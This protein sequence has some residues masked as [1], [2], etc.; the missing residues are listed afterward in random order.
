MNR[1]MWNAGRVFVVAIG[2]AAL[3]G[4][5]TPTAVNSQGIGA[6]AKPVQPDAV[7]EVNRL[8][9]Q[10]LALEKRVAELEKEELEKFK[11]EDVADDAREKKLEQRLAS[12]EKAQAATKPDTKAGNKPG[13]ADDDQPMTVRAPF[14]VVDAANR[15]IFSVVQESTITGKDAKGA[16]KQVTSNRGLNVYN[17]QGDTVAR[18]AVLDGDGYVSARQGGLG[19]LVGGVQAVLYADKDGSHIGLNGTSKKR[20]VELSSGDQGLTFFNDAGMA[21]TQVSRT[22]FWMGDE[23]GNG[24]VEAGVVDKRGVVRVGPRFGGPLGPGQLGF[25]YQIVGRK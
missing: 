6:Q 3:L 9:Q 18:V 21:L 20:N 1:T 24:M 10:L 15:P 25:P 4:A 11:G 12:L 16:D 2:C 17:A 23:A 8:R 13:K 19:D 7:A 22:K 14:T 5:F